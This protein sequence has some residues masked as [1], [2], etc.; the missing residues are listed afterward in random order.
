MRMWKFIGIMGKNFFEV[1]LLCVK[2]KIRKAKKMG[3]LSEIKMP[4]N[5]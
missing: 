1:R 3:A 5:I 2:K 4:R